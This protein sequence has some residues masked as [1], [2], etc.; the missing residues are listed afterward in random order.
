[1]PFQ[2]V[3]VVV[4]DA[5]ECKP[6]VQAAAAIADE[7]RAHLTG[8]GLPLHYMPIVYGWEGS[9][10]AE[11]YEDLRAESNAKIKAAADLFLAEIRRQ[12]LEATS[13]W[14]M[15][16]D[17]AVQ[18]IIPL[19]RHGDVVVAPLPRV[20]GAMDI[21]SSVLEGLLFHSGC[22]LLFVPPGARTSVPDTI[23]VAWNGSREA[24]RAVR[25]A[26]PLLA[27]AR[28]VVV[29]AVDSEGELARLGPDPVGRI[30][31]HLA[32]HNP[33]VEGRLLQADGRSTGEVLLAAAADEGAGLIVM[34]AYGHSRARE[35]LLGGATRH[36]MKHATIQVFMS[37]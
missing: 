21:G 35:R 20:G 27:D 22:P 9:V 19:V 3:M 24:A 23:F 30:T 37:H 17:T 11:L 36:V 12:G 32:R 13:E 10:N 34:G 2:D 18:S 16:G 14:C 26:A 5:E 29:G 7:H 25:D 8:I 6:A 15:L 1:M 31:D 28:R 33:R 4:Y